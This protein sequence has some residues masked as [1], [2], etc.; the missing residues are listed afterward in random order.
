MKIEGVT[1]HAFPRPEALVAAGV[2]ELRAIKFSARKSEY[3]VDIAATVASGKLELEGLHHLPDDEVIRVLTSIRGVGLWT[4]QWLLIRA[5]GRSDGFPYSDLA[6][7]RTLGILVSEG[8]HFQPE[9]ALQYSGRWSPFRSYVTAYLFAAV[10]S[11]RLTELMSNKASSHP[12][13]APRA[14]TSSQ[15]DFHMFSVR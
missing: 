14:G 7:Q 6:L 13:T 1:Y 2:E 8:K 9:E 5:L 4:A 15:G 3:I 11:G 10:R 12:I